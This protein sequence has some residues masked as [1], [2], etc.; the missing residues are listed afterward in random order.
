MA[1]A[2][3]DWSSALSVKSSPSDCRGHTDTDIAAGV[4]GKATRS[5]TRRETRQTA[6]SD[7]QA[8]DEGSCIPKSSR[9]RSPYGALKPFPDKRAPGKTPFDR[10]TMVEVPP[11]AIQYP[12]PL[13]YYH[14]HQHRVHTEHPQ[15]VE[16]RQPL[17]RP[18]HGSAASVSSP[19][20]HHAPR[21]PAGS[22][23]V[24][25]ESTDG[26]RGLSAGD[27]AAN[28]PTWTTCIDLHVY[29]TL[30]RSLRFALT[31]AVLVYQYEYNM[32]N[33]I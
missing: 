20:V 25:Q 14:H 28:R 18:Q 10:S 30:S 26:H 4:G 1:L 7:M 8:A 31:C 19:A 16:R 6:Q 33:R 23:A 24:W 11:T 12:Q 13:S 17:G 9:Y 29:L 3:G 2:S 15:P 21:H 32:L 5:D 27:S 22:A